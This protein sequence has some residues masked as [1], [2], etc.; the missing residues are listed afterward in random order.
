MHYIS[1]REPYFSFIKNKK[2]IIEGRL[3]TGKYSLFKKND[4]IKINNKN[5]DYI[6][7]QITKLK[8]YKT[9]EEYLSREGLNRTL[10]NIKTI[11]DGVDIYHAFYS[12]NDEIKYGVLAIYIK[13]I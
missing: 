10:P 8:K 2:K 6:I 1:V 13:K 4:T 7:V 9:F 5:N 12:I 11:S 3:N